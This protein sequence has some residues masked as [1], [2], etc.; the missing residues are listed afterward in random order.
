MKV[1]DLRKKLM[2]ALVAGGTLAPSALYAANLD[3]NLVTNGGFENVNLG[4]TGAYNAPLILDW[5]GVNG[6]AYSHNGTAG[7]PDFAEGP[8]PPEAGNWYFTSNSAPDKTAANQFYQDID[9]SGG[10]TGAA[11][12][13]G[14]AVYNVSAWMSSF[15]N[16]GDVARLHLNFRNSGGT[17]LATALYSDTDPGSGN[18]WS[19]VSRAGSVPIGTTSVRLSVYG[20]PVAGGP[21]GYIDNVDFQVSQAGEMDLI[22]TIVDRWSLD[23]SVSGLPIVY[24]HGRVANGQPGNYEIELSFFATNGSADKGWLSSAFDVQDVGPGLDLVLGLWAPINPNVDINGPPPP[25]AV[26]PHYSVNQDAGGDPSDLQRITASLANS[27]LPDNH[28]FDRRNEVGTVDAYP[29][30]KVADGSSGLGRFFVS[31]DGAGTSD[32]VIKNHL[33]VFSRLPSGPGPEQQGEGASVGFGSSLS[34]DYNLDGSVDAA[35][36]VVWRK[37]QE[38]GL[39]DLPNDENGAGPIGAAEYSL[40]RSHFGY[41]VGG[42]S[43]AG[44]G[45]AGAPAGNIPEPTSL[46]FCGFGAVVSLASLVGR[47]RNIIGH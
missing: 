23:F 8:N 19:L 31:W 41:T 24:E 4:V 3:T 22:A 11:I 42:G 46:G 15:A 16:D 21:D 13:S 26:T 1:T 44:Q 43:T 27:S 35:D 5:S 33:F 2:A 6:F 30:V 32:L 14:K 38:S 9:V 17:S 45:S 36:Y 10:D 20:T 40:W 47:R 28:A 39:D 7:V 25:G 12:A 37:A 29:S 18:V 34:G